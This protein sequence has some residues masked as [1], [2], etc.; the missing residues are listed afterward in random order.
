MKR[1][2]HHE[3]GI[4]GVQEA[5]EYAKAHE[6][7][8]RLVY[9]PFLKDMKRLNVSGQ[10]LEVGAGPG[11]FTSLLAR[12]NPDVHMTVTDISPD[13]VALARKSLADKNIRDRLDFALCDVK[14]EQAVERL[15]QFD[16]IYSIYSLHHWNDPERCILNLLRALKS[17][18]LLYIGDLKRVWWL[19]YM[20]FMSGDVQQIRASYRPSEIRKLFEQHHIT[21]YEIRTLFPFFLQSIIVR[22]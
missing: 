22:R 15:G 1:V 14:D 8:G 17:G 3:E 11:L 7:H 2:I 4:T 18:G 21:G 20:P 13:M 10:C 6:K 19:Y 12:E 5:E 16:M 9:A